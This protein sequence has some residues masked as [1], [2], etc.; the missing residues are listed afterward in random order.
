[1]SRVPD[2]CWSIRWYRARLSSESSQPE[3][4]KKSDTTTSNM[5][6]I[7]VLNQ[8]DCN[9]P[10]CIEHGAGDS[11]DEE[12]TVESVNNNGKV[13]KNPLRNFYEI[14]ESRI[15]RKKINPI[16]LLQNTAKISPKINIYCSRWKS[17]T[18]KRLS[19]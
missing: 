1:M 11:Y 10:S 7:Q 18:S 15:N 12:D 8:D 3:T 17:G 19:K 14:F 4:D 2:I 5:S 13:S 6:S 9:D 16:K